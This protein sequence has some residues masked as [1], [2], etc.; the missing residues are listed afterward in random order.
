MNDDVVRYLQANGSRYTRQALQRR[1]LAAGFSAD[2]IDEA[3]QAMVSEG[4]GGAAGGGSGWDRGD[5]SGGS[6]AKVRLRSSGRFWAGLIGYV[7][8]A[9]LGLAFVTGG[10]LV[11]LIGGWGSL[12][13]LYILIVLVGG[14]V[15]WAVRRTVDWPLAV[16]VGCG[17]VVAIALPFIFIIGVI[18]WCLITQPTM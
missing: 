12:A 4:G 15:F 1:L 7:V 18:G 16:G 3:A 6:A 10:P 11:P 8:L 17:V 14:A 9:Y 5:R 2:E 13:P